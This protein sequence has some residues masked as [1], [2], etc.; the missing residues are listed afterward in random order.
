MGVRQSAAIKQDFIQ[1]NQKKISLSGFT[2][3]GLLE[4]H[5][6]GYIYNWIVEQ[7]GN[8]DLLV[9]KMIPKLQLYN[10]KKIKA[11]IRELFMM[12]SLQFPFLIQPFCAFQDTQDLYLVLEYVPGGDL[13]TQLKLQS[14]N[15]GEAK[16]LI[17]QLLIALNFLHQ[18]RVIHTNLN[19]YNILLDNSGY[20][21]LYGLHSSSCGGQFRI[22]DDISEYMAPEVLLREEFG[23]EADYYSIGVLLYE[24]MAQRKMYEYN[25]IDDMIDNIINKQVSVKKSE[26]SE[27]W[28]LDA[29]DFINKLIQKDP[30]NRLGYYGFQDIKKH[31]W[32][33]GVQ[34]QKIEEKILVNTFIPKQVPYS[35]TIHKQPPH[36][37]AI[38]ESQ[39][40][41]NL[42]S[43][44]QYR[45]DEEVKEIDYS[46]FI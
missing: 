10:E 38:V 9:M 16:M 33:E 18:K 21:K 6:R 39:D 13:R 12:V 3:K 30:K 11:Y 31:I 7:D 1:L 19:P 32:M 27:G 20:I 36:T 22:E 34:W 23:F 17:A 40:F 42:F 29:A 8:P 43:L 15:E 14:M 46:R 24:I 35:T 37:H 2:F 41:Q 5:S 25:S 45:W 28:S 26:L 4:H 44:F